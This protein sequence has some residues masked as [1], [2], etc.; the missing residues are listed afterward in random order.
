MRGAR[1]VHLNPWTLRSGSE[2]LVLAPIGV[3]QFGVS[4]V[5]VFCLPDLILPIGAKE[6]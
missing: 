2:H 5:T 3:G 4:R 1:Y 6:L